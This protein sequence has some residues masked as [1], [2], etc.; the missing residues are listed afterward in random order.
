MSVTFEVFQLEIS[1]LKDVS[2]SNMPC[3]MVTLAVFQLE[4]SPLIFAI[5]LNVP[6][7][8]VTDDKSGASVAFISMFEQSANAPAKYVQT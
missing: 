7:R 2:P 1:L 3:I 5:P 8:E 6:A 4:R